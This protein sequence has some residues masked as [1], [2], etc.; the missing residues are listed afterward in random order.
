MILNVPYFKQIIKSNLIFFIAFTFILCAF[1]TVI[2]NVFTPD[3]MVGIETAVNGT[4]AS[5][6]VHGATFVEFLSNSFYAIMAIIFPM[7]YSIIVGNNLI[8]SKVDD[9]S[10]AN[11]LSTLV[12]RREI[13]ISSALYLILSLLLMWIVATIVGITAAEIAQP[14]SLDIDTFIMLNV[15]VFLFHFAVSS[16]C[17]I[18]SCIFNSSK[19]SLIIG[20][21]IPLLFFIINL[22]VKL[23]EDLEPLKYV[24]LTTLF[25][26]ANIIA[27]SGYTGD[28]IVLAIIG[29]VLYVI[30]IEVF[31]RKSLPL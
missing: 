12:S 6:I 8:A 14:D 29:I 9:G 23:S 25:D 31:S 7:L 18:A 28:F 24:T 5:N 11:Y 1:L 19:N 15:G 13:V 17:F 22:L 2:C 20:G 16:I 4:F 27:G 30:G 10:M 21:G 3:S 26:T